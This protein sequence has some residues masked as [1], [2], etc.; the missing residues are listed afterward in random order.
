M[1]LTSYNVDTL[2]EK[3]D[4]GVMSDLDTEGEGDGEQE[5]KRLASSSERILLPSVRQRPT[6]SYG[7]TQPAT[8]VVS[9][10][11]TAAPVRP[12]TGAGTVKIPPTPQSRKELDESIRK[13]HRKMIRKERK[14]EQVDLL[15][16]VCVCV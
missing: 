9:R 12:A 11:H 13:L 5:D 15:V 14:V 2:E 8:A 1:T 3:E 7:V 4:E 10:P 6:S 16:C